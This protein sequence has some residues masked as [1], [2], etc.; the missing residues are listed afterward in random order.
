DNNLFFLLNAPTF[1]Y[2]TSTNIKH[3]KKGQHLML[4][5]KA[6]STL[7][8]STD[9]PSPLAPVRPRLHHHDRRWCM[10]ALVIWSRLGVGGLGH[11]A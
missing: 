7:A 1:A 10:T 2:F 4:K 6:R 9:I 3:Q 5:G 8:L 11:N